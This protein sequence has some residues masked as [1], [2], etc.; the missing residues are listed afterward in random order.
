MNFEKNFSISLFGIIHIDVIP[1]IIGMYI[2]APSTEYVDT[3]AGIIMHVMIQIPI[4][5]FFDS[6]NFVPVIS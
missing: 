5:L 2:L 3:I 1:K 4:T 6:K